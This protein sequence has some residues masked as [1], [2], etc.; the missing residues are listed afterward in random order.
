[1]KGYFPDDEEEE[2]EAAQPAV[3]AS[4]QYAFQSNG[5]SSLPSL[6]AV[7]N[8]S[9][10]SFGRI[11]LLDLLFRYPALNFLSCINLSHHAS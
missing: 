8:G 2:A 3:D 1:M 5:E 4:G 7:A 11:Q 9:G 10:G 6:R